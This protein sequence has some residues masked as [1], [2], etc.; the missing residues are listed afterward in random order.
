[1]KR[2]G[3]VFHELLIQ[4]QLAKTNCDPQTSSGTLGHYDLQVPHLQKIIVRFKPSGGGLVPDYVAYS[5][6]ATYFGDALRSFATKA[7]LK[8]F[9]FQDMRKLSFSRD[10]VPSPSGDQGEGKIPESN[11]E[12]TEPGAEPEVDGDADEYSNQRIEIH[13]EEIGV[14][15][16]DVGFH[17]AAFE[18]F[19]KVLDKS[20]RCS[21]ELRV[22]LDHRI[23]GFE[24]DPEPPNDGM[25]RFAQTWTTKGQYLGSSSI[26]AE[27]D[28]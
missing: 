23:D 22:T 17:H 19:T 28:R 9:E 20:L 18:D 8:S 12:S 16:S 15:F 26:E 25:Y 14:T 3:N 13:D 21:S 5:E 10:E 27:L 6:E 7:E 24:R 4:R 2:L 11:T 1:M